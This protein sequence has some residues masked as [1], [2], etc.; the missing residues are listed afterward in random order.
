[1]PSVGVHWQQA[2]RPG[3]NSSPHPLLAFS[4]RSSEDLV[5]VLHFTIHGSAEIQVYGELPES[6]PAVHGGTKEEAHRAGF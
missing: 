5:F 4:L 3:N 1:M 6:P 2:T